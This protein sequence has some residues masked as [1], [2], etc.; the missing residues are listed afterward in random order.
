MT[1]R[2]ASRLPGLALLAAVGLAGRAVGAVTGINHLIATIG[3]GAVLGNVVGVPTRYA[4]G[5]RTYK[6]WLETGIVLMGAGV[7]LGQ[8]LAA[9]PLVFGLV[10]VVVPG[11]VVV[12]EAL[13]RLFGFPRKLGSL[14]ASGASICGV[15]AVV[16]VAGSIDAD[17]AHVAYASGTILLFDALTLVAYPAVGEVLGLSDLAFGVWAG[18]TMFS[19]GPVAAAGFAYSQAAGEWATLTKL[20]RNALI[21]VVALGYAVWYVRLGGESE[22]ESE[23]GSGLTPTARSWRERAATLWGEFPK[24]FVG[25]VVLLVFGNLVLT[26]P[27]RQAVANAADWA[28]LLAFA[29]LGVGLRLDALRE[30][31]WRPFVAVLVSLLAFSAGV[32]AAVT[33]LF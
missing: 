10:A 5:V 24:F 33:T 18:T 6:L 26:A 32:L 27:T 8:V 13:G 2:I 17:D 25:F 31:G 28:F 12:V 15:S 7:A 4:P 19:T 14:L 3:I 1:V 29:G 11:T 21:G 9:G 23:S 22:S 16:S 20:A 30:A